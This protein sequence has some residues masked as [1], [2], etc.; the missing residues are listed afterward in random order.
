M[1][2]LYTRLHLLILLIGL[3]SSLWA[4]EQDW[5]LGAFVRHAEIPFATQSDT[6]TSFVPMMF[7]QWEHFFIKGTANNYRLRRLQE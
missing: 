5:G 2:I 6:V 4:T 1:R 3:N 7:Y